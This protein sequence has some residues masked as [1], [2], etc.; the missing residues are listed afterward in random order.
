[1]D[2]SDEGPWVSFTIMP[3]DGH[4]DYLVLGQISNCSYKSVSHILLVDYTC[5]YLWM[6]WS[7]RMFSENMIKDLFFSRALSM[8]HT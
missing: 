4:A 6:G 8:I 1:M 3:H 2:S 5:K 7:D